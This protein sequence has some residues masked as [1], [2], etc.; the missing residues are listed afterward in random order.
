M[1]RLAIILSL[2]G[3]LAVISAWLVLGAHTGWTRMK[4]E[5]KKVD[6]VTEIEFVEYRPGFVPGV[7]FL[8][9]GLGGCTLLLGAGLILSRRRS[10]TINT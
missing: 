8:A 5:T 3:F 9:A 4:I 7:D 6:P 1:G 10:K 2:A